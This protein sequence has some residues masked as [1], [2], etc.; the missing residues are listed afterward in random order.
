MRE[1]RVQK[2]KGEKNRE[3]GSISR[4][5]SRRMHEKQRRSVIKIME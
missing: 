1:M 4:R 2:R 3:R 5:V